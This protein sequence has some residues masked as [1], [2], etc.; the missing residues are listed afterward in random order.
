MTDTKEKKEKKQ[1]LKN[2][3][4]HHSDDSDDDGCKGEKV[5]LDAVKKKK[6]VK[7]DTAELRVQREMS[8]VMLYQARIAKR[9]NKMKKI[10]S[11]VETKNGAR[12]KTVGK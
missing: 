5:K 1:K 6:K 8:K 10:K 3:K 7:E 12:N 9:K 2:G 11:V 4:K